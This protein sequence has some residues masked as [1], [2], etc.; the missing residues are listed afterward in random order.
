MLLAFQALQIAPFNRNKDS[1]LVK[2]Y[3]LGE[4]ADLTIKILQ[5]IRTCQE[6]KKNS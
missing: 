1:T 3:G 6:S 4:W 5:K 2:Q